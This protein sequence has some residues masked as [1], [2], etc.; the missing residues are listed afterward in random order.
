V[1]A[2]R[3]HELLVAMVARYMRDQGYELV[4]LDCSFSWIF[5]ETFR[6]PPSITLHRPDVLGVRR[7]PPFICIG[8]G[9]TRNDIRSARTRRQL[10]DFT[11]APIHGVPCGCAVV[12]GIPEDC[13][14]ALEHVLVSLGISNNRIAILPIPRPLLN[15]KP[16]A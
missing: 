9:K 13:K 3:E 10:K 12:V 11:H 14:S 5:G 4:A 6:L 15:A 2:T 7:E 16:R 1:S 8:E